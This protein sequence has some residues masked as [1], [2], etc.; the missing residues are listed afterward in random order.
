MKSAMILAMAALAL[1]AAPAGDARRGE[2]LFET[3]QC[4]QCHSVN[5]RGGSI[6]PD[7][8]RRVDRDYTPTV[9]ASM[10]WNHA[11]DMWSAM[12]KQG[13]TKASMTPDAAADLFAYFVSARDFEKPGDAGRGKQAFTAKHCSECHGVS[14]SN[15]AG[16]PPVAK[17]ES[18]SDPI[19]LAQQMWN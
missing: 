3:E 13:I 9:M 19:I 5:G 12:K 8:T 16:A 17:W 14:L 11:P 4:I 6:A 18:L 15:A 7:L 2:K 1:R 10:M